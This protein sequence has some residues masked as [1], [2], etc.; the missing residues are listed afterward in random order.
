MTTPKHAGGRP[1]TGNE[2]HTVSLPPALWAHVDA[3]EGDT[4]SARL[5]VVVGRDAEQTLAVKAQQVGG[6]T[7]KITLDEARAQLAEVISCI[8]S[9]LQ[10]TND[11]H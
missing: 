5:A 2:R 3:Q 8:Y 4:R 7:G 9:E 11:G 10:E 6:E 1:R